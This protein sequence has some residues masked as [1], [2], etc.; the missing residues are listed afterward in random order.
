MKI[1]QVTE[2][3]CRIHCIFGDRHA[4]RALANEGLR[5]FVWVEDGIS[6]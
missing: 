1:A 4:F 6:G 2:S 5:G 3:E